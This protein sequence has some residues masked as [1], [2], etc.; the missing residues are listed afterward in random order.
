M[1]KYRGDSFTLAP[2]TC[3]NTP[4]TTRPIDQFNVISCVIA[5]LQFLE[6]VSVPNDS[7]CITSFL[8]WS[9]FGM[10][11]LGET[12][13]KHLGAFHPQYQTCLLCHILWR[14]AKW[15][16]RRW[17][18]NKQTTDPEVCRRLWDWQWECHWLWV[19]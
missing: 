12:H 8:C 9:R 1:G 7:R 18:K 4:T 17:K 2:T 13:K 19:G 5:V 15:E 11:L 6:N 10:L 16:N 3:T 14:W